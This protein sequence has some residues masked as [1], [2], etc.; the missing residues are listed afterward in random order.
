MGFFDFFAK[1]T[2]TTQVLVKELPKD[3][4]YIPTEKEKLLFLD[5]VKGKRVDQIF[6]GNTSLIQEYKRNSLKDWL[7]N[8]VLGHLIEIS[9][10]NE[11]IAI[12]VSKNELVNICKDLNFP[13][14][15]N[16]INLV[17]RIV[18][19]DSHYF[20]NH[21]IDDWF[22]ITKSGKETLD[23]FKQ[24][25]NHVKNEM[26]EKVLQ[27]LIAHQEIKAID[28]VVEYR[29]QYP[30]K[31]SGFFLVFSKESLI[32]IINQINKSDVFHNLGFSQQEVESLKLLYCRHYLLTDVFIEDEIEKISSGALAL[33]KKSRLI[34]NKDFPLID[35]NN[36]LRGYKVKKYID[37]KQSKL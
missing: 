11:S 13:I 26:K 25:E 17:N 6:F 20:D 14:S 4:L 19:R 22:V 33:I 9:S 23:D 2:K 16:K 32:E 27:C 21:Q 28:L 12:S 37:S 30:F 18:E 8:S 15:G 10:G 31:D 35:L 1:K 5:M 36:L 34:K 29:N 24:K 7:Y 3:N